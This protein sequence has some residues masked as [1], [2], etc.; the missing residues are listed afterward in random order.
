MDFYAFDSWN[1][2]NTQ[3]GPDLWTLAIDNDTLL[4]TTFSKD[5]NSPQ[6]YPENYPATYTGTTGA[7]ATNL[8]SLN[9]NPTHNQANKTQ[10]FFI[11]K[12]AIHNANSASITFRIN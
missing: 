5:N 4:H 3:W 12:S 6:S 9:L 11:N 7:V 1:G 10:K 2:N 8:E